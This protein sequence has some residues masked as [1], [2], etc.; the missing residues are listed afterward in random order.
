VTYDSNVNVLLPL[1][2]M[3]KNTK[4]SLSKYIDNL[5]EGS[6]TN[7]SGGLLK[8]LEQFSAERAPNTVAT[9]LLMTDGLANEGITD[10]NNLVAE[11]KSR[12]EKSANSASV[13]TFGFGKNHEENMLRAIAEN[14]GGMYYF[15]ENLDSI[16]ESYGDCLGG[17]LSV[18]AQNIKLAIKP[19]GEVKISRVLGKFKFVQEGNNYVINIGDLYSEETRDIVC[20]MT[21]PSVPE[22][23]VADPVIVFDLGYFNIAVNKFEKIEKTCTVHRTKDPKEQ[24]R[25]YTL[26]KHLNR[27]FTAEA[28]EQARAIGSSD[29]KKAQGIID[30]V[31]EKVKSSISANDELC[32]KLLA[33]LNEVKKDLEDEHKFHST[34]SKKLSSLSHGHH[35]QRNTT[36]GA[37]TYVTSSKMY[38]QNLSH[39]Q[40]Q[41]LKIE[42]D[43]NL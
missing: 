35:M 23:K 43:L 22:E 18:V 42:A 40:D 34:T 8:G 33:D 20:A 21:L 32:V 25:D 41:D 29:L 17:L 30:A 14:A 4:D 37:Q 24:K 7:L 12:R 11:L 2:L 31:I 6:N 5:K 3:T 27:L 16:A 26:D 39:D 38:Y 9:V 19:V 36:S 10:M 1:T 15:I 13:F 28:M